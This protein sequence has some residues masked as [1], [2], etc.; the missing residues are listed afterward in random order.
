MAQL[1]LREDAA[2]DTLLVRGIEVEDA[3]ALLFTRDDR[4]YASQAALATEPVADPPRPHEAAAFLSRRAAFALE[5]LT[6]RYPTL[7]R[8]RA[9]S[10][11]PAWLS[12]GVAIGAALEGRLPI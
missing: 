9:L 4:Q 7:E 11:W 8:V 3:S 6:A 5:R 12:W 2:I 10:R 1:R